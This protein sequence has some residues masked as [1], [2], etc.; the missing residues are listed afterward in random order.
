MIVA[1]GPKRE[2]ILFIQEGIVVYDIRLKGETAA[3]IQRRILHLAE[4]RWCTDRIRREA[5]AIAKEYF[6]GKVAN[7]EAA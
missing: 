2:Y 5:E 1:I 4:K 3:D 6:S 7:A